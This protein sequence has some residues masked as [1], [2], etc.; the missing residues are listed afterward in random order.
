MGISLLA[1]GRGLSQ[2]VNQDSWLSSLSICPTTP[3]LSAVQCTVVTCSF[4]DW[5]L[6]IYKLATQK[7]TFAIIFGDLCFLVFFSVWLVILVCIVRG[8]E[9]SLCVVGWK[10]HL[11]FGCN[12]LCTVLHLERWG[13]SV[14][15]AWSC[16][17]NSTLVRWVMLKYPLALT[18]CGRTPLAWSFFK[19]MHCK[20][21]TKAFRMILYAIW[22]TVEFN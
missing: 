13:S 8:M 18:K 9:I 11:D 12:I 19:S 15:L 21:F 3:W 7:D 1:N 20:S 22:L 2:R 16:C 6:F 10:M 5:Q 4:T 14:H 17:L